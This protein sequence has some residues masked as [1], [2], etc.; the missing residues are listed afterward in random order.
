MVGSVEQALIITKSMCGAAS[1]GER[2][3]RL[4]DNF[5]GRMISAFQ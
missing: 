3:L 1:S 5:S 2:D 4:S